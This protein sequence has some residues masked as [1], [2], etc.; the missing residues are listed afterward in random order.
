MMWRQS[1]RQINTC[2]NVSGLTQVLKRTIA[3]QQGSTECHDKRCQVGKAI[4]VRVL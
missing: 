1:L 4:A 2:C 3:S